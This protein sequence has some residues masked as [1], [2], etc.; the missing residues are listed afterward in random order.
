[1]NVLESIFS[2]TTLWWIMMVLYIPSCA[3]LII[4]VLLQKGKGSGFAGAFGLGGGGD[5]VFGPRASQSL[6]V[7][8]THIMAAVFMIMALLMSMI[9][10]K[11]GRGVAPDEVAAED[12]QPSISDTTIEELG[13]G[14]FTEEPESEDAPAPEVSVEPSEE[15]APVET[16]AEEAPAEAESPDTDET[17]EEGDAESGN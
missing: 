5:T 15:E 16:D 2:W 13:I 3:G 12:V 14:E 17:A 10:G 8:M 1:M 7:R 11:V 6:P 9:A 4:I